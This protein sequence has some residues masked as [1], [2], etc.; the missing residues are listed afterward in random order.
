M[1]EFGADYVQKQLAGGGKLRVLNIVD[2]FNSGIAVLDNHYK[3][4][5]WATV[6]SFR[7]LRAQVPME[8]RLLIHVDNG[9]PFDNEVVEAY[10]Q[11]AN[12]ELDFI[13]KGQPWNNPYVERSNRTV[14]E[15]FLNLEFI[16]GVKHAQQVLDRAREKF[17]QRENMNLD[18]R[19]PAQLW[20]DA[21]LA[22]VS[23]PAY[24]PPLEAAA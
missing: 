22:R 2:H 9:K 12:I 13:P 5:A 20:E 15:Q 19:T 8:Q 18:Y 23:T 16:A 10:C 21:R 24:Q 17:N 11:G 14:K 6:A 7:E 4:S 3:E 1:R